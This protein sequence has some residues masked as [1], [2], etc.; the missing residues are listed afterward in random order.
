MLLE[1]E[2]SS[3]NLGSFFFSNYCRHIHT[4]MMTNLTSQGKIF[5]TY[6]ILYSFNGGSPF[7]ISSSIDSFSSAKKHCIK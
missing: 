5:M 1:K 4:Q 7:L 2:R 6:I 3:E